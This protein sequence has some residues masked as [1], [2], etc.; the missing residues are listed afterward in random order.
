MCLSV[1]F[2]SMNAFGQNTKKITEKSTAKTEKL[3]KN[4]VP[5]A[6][7]ETF[8]AGYP[9][10]ISESWFGYPQF[11]FVNEWYVLDPNLYNYENPQYYVVEFL[12]DSIPY[13]AVYTKEGAPVSTHKK[14]ESELPKAITDAISKG[15]YS[16]WQVL[17]EKEVAYKKSESEKI[18][19]YK[20]V[21]ANGAEK[22]HLFYTVEGELLKDNYFYSY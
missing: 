6:V 11:D 20:I 3:E 4:K 16:N 18:R 1:A 21:V 8:I 13:H 2:V 17:R 12:K 15:K 14:V 10:I 7:R 9:E 19:V 22:H 5:K